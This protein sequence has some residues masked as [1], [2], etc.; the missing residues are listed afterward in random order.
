[1]FLAGLKRFSPFV[2]VV[3]A[4][5]MIVV[6]AVSNDGRTRS[7][8]QLLDGGVWLPTTLGSGLVQLIDGNARNSVDALGALAAVDAQGNFTVW[9]AGT[10]A[11]V[12]DVERAG[13]KLMSLA[14]EQLGPPDWNTIDGV[15]TDPDRA[16]SD[17]EVLVD[18]DVAWL[19][20]SDAGVAQQYGLPSLTPIGGPVDLDQDS[21]EWQSGAV[22]DGDLWGL[23]S[24]GSL[25][26]PADP[27]SSIPVMESGFGGHLSTAGERL[28]AVSDTGRVS[29][30]R[31]TTTSAN[32]DAQ[33]QS[34]IDEVVEVVGGGLAHG[35]GAIVGANGTVGLVSA[36][37]DSLCDINSFSVSD[38]ADDLTNAVFADGRV[39]I[40]NQATGE[41]TARLIDG[42]DISQG[43][44]TSALDSFNLVAEGKAVFV[45]DIT[46]PAAGVIFA[47]G[48][49]LEVL[50]VDKQT[51]GSTDG[52]EIGTSE[53]EEEEPGAG[54]EGES[55]PVDARVDAILLGTAEDGT[56]QGTEIVSGG[57]GQA[58][59]ADQVGVEVL[60]EVQEVN[61]IRCVTPA[62]V[63]VEGDTAEWQLILNDQEPEEVNV[64]LS[65]SGDDVEFDSF[66]LELESS[67]PGVLNPTVFGE[68]DGVSF[69]GQACQPVT[70]QPE[71]APEP[72]TASIGIDPEPIDGQLPEGVTEVRIFDSS[73]PAPEERTW[74][75]TSPS[76]ESSESEEEF[77]IDVSEPGIYTIEITV[78]G[79]EGQVGT[80]TRGF[81][82]VEAGA[83]SEDEEETEQEENQEEQVEE[84]GNQ[85]VDVEVQVPD[86]ISASLGQAQQRLSQVGLVARVRDRETCA[87]GQTIES[88]TVF[89][90]DPFPGAFVAPGSTVSLDLAVTCLD[91]EVELTQ[92]PP[93][94]GLEL[95]DAESSTAVAGLASSATPPPPC[96]GNLVASPVG[97]SNPAAGDLVP[98]GS[99]VSLSVSYEC[100]FTMP[101]VVG[102]SQTAATNAIAAAGIPNP[103]QVV[104]PP[105]SILCLS[106]AVARTQVG[107]TIPGAGATILSDQTPTLNL[108]TTCVGGVQDICV[109]SPAACDDILILDPC[110]LNPNGV[111]CVEVIDLCEINPQACE[112]LVI[113]VDPPQIETVPG[114]IEPGI[115]GPV[116]GLDP[117]IVIPEG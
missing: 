66:R 33:C 22:I 83:E 61:E 98:P 3:L 7:E 87:S 85:E 113:D 77:N 43:E 92:V 81:A 96:A 88:E 38:S 94:I 23:Y 91:P 34:A 26:K 8:V 62:D 109:I 105:F 116:E 73:D 16:D 41:L 18:R 111:G 55:G 117:A 4:I 60:G 74:L 95:A 24:D 57:D 71:S 99:V 40:G 72:I 6:A 53:D 56:G 50:A 32:L 45:N 44:F 90:S 28:M 52:S 65:N 37:I 58:G 14:T 108:E 67:E 110:D 11:L 112:P 15:E 82:V 9:Q 12:V 42:S 106:P 68:V 31:T 80:A 10:D 78:T 79:D 86:T 93:V 1:M 76:A 114:I 51:Q 107:S 20:V 48:D 2:A 21:R 103:P 100:S 27:D 39:F 17:V 30:L 64:T 59:D 5:A 25:A 13:L 63:I 102:M 70:V 101:N 47:D 29:L 49:G 54:Q 104:P 69:A 46:S 75:V 84:E 115:I 35:A 36:E 97:S 19:V 89:R